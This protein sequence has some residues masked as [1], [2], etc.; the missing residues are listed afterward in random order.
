MSYQSLVLFLMVYGG[1]CLESD[2]IINKTLYKNIVDYFFP[3]ELLDLFNIKMN[4]YLCFQEG[5][6]CCHCAQIC[7]YYGTCCVDVFFNKNVRSLEEYV[8]ILFEKTRIKHHVK[9]LP[10][11]NI[12]KNSAKFNVQKVLMVSSCD[13]KSSIYMQ[14]CNRNDSS[15][16]RRIE[17]DSFIYRNKYCALCHGFVNF[18]NIILELVSSQT[19]T[20]KTSN[21]TSILDESF[22]LQMAQDKSER[23][24]TR[25]YPKRN[26]LNCSKNDENLC[27]SSYFALIRSND[28]STHAN[29][30]CAKCEK[31]QN[32]RNL[33][34]LQV[35]GSHS[36]PRCGKK[37]H[38]RLLMSLDKNGE[39][40]EILVK[41][42]PICACDQY[43]DI[44]T[45]QCKKKLYGSCRPLFP[46]TSETTQSTSITPDLSDISSLGP[47]SGQLSTELPPT[48]PCSPGKSFR[49]GPSSLPVKTLSIKL[50]RNFAETAILEKLYQCMKAINGS[51]IYTQFNDTL[52]PALKKYQQSALCSNSFAKLLRTSGQFTSLYLVPYNKIPYTDIYGFSLNRHFLFNRVCANVEVFDNNFEVTSDCSVKHNGKTYSISNN[53]IYWI[54]ISNSQVYYAASRCKRFHLIPNCTIGILNTSQVT[55]ANNVAFAKIDGKETY[56]SNEQYLPLAEGLGV[57]YEKTT[58]TLKQYHWL[59]RYYYFENI[60]SLSLLSFSISFEIVFL[61]IY[62]R[63]KKLQSVLGKNLIAL[64]FSLLVCDIIGITLTLSDVIKRLS[65]RI[66]AAVLHLFSLSLCTWTCVIAYD[67]WSTFQYNTIKIK[68]YNIYLRYSLLA[69]GVPVTVVLACSFLHVL[70]EEKY[71]AYGKDDYCW[72]SP[73]GALLTTYLIPFSLMTLGSC[74]VILTAIIQTKRKKKKNDEILGKENQMNFS[75]MAFKL[76]LLLGTAELIG[77]IQIPNAKLKGQSALIFNIIFGFIYNLLRSSR[78]IFLFVTFL[79]TK[80]VK[81]LVIQKHSKF[82]GIS[83]LF[84]NLNSYIKETST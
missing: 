82:L 38:F 4:R 47:P 54:N 64:C 55:L 24:F 50:A 23:D 57:C 30:F 17:A 48:K 83:K 2:S 6:T 8:D 28:G 31:K 77:L 1:K 14:L 42:T 68:V 63:F 59:E 29:P 76:S 84:P 9:R 52:N 61:V 40:T 5:S 39:S 78:G 62:I 60:L 26:K 11:V 44:F 49:V 18:T 7:R 13:N 10:I 51:L 15:S 66:V 75:K 46:S 45:N 71:I 22:S 27:F 12:N 74:I 58:L 81:N 53:V 25:L 56:Y 73:V 33:Y 37:P 80:Q 69:W 67:L 34:C 65:C 35:F 79:L 19:V 16:D 43:I 21:E 20:N 70:S 36:C 41:G 72:I 32:L 3:K